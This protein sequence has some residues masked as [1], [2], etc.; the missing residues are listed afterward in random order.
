[1]KVPPLHLSP[2]P[3]AVTQ[4]MIPRTTRTL[5]ILIVF[6]IALITAAH[7]GSS[8]VHYEGSAGPYSIRVLIRT[9]GVIPGLAQI[10]VR[11]TDGTDVRHVTVRP[12][13]SDAGLEGAPPA[14]TA[15]GVEG[16]AN[17]YSAELWLMRFGSYSVH[18]TVSGEQGTGT[19]FVP[20][21]AVAERRLAM[22]VPMAIA[23]IGAGLFL[24]V[25]VLTIFGAAARESVLPP[26]ETPDAKR[27]RR[28]KVAMVGGGVVV[29]LVVMGGMSWWND[30]DAAYQRRI[31]QPL[32]TSARF[33]AASGRIVLTLT[34]DDPAWLGRSWTPLIPDHGKLMH[35]F[36]VKHD[37]LAAFAHL[38]PV[39][40]DS[41]TFAVA[42][43]RLPAGNYRVYADIVHESGFTQTLTNLVNLPP[44]LAT[45][46]LDLTVPPRDP[47]DSWT[48]TQPFGAA[49]T[50]AMPLPSGRTITW[51]RE[52]DSFVV[53]EDMT[54]RF[55]V[56]NADGTPAA[57]EPYLGM[58]S[59]AAVTLHDGSV[60]IHLHPAG[61]INMAA[62]ARFE[63]VE[64]TASEQA[65]DS[66]MA[67]PRSGVEEN[68]VTFPFAF[69]KPGSYRVW[70]QTKVAG[71]VET[72]VWD[73]EVT[74]RR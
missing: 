68:V 60:F 59:H 21:L 9:P 48:M 32:H 8:N 31:F 43:P 13:R 69:P 54:M 36:L 61:T 47:D 62:K 74:D 26:G 57:L 25:G 56:R 15:L 11:I 58:M 3:P 34:I 42:F 4:R 16:D 14:D 33:A 45:Q 24:F 39:S 46:S 29:A 27:V 1:M 7:V 19:A 65:M 38:H 2:R 22:S 28:G 64:G 10:T 52:D 51:E 17:L 5:R 67:M 55:V 70:V 40:T 63:R 50:R 72:G 71:E 35:M 37:D 23:L 49:S 18:V 41:N 30:L 66:S 20:V 12:V 44:V 73:V 6:A 53:D